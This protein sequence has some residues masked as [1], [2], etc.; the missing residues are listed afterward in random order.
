MPEELKAPPTLLRM[1]SP[2]CQGVLKDGVVFYIVFRVGIRPKNLES[3]K[4]DVGICQM[5]IGALPHDGQPFPRLTSVQ[6]TW[7]G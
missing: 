1:E 5:S 6:N 4:F 7:S 3:R 2:G